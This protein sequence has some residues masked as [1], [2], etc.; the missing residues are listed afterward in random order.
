MT[1]EK[2]AQEKKNIDPSQMEVPSEL[3]ILTL[4][5]FVFFPG[6]GF[7]LQVKNEPS[8]KLIDDILLGDRL[9]ALVTHKP[10]EEE[11]EKVKPENLYS[12]GVM[13]YIHKL[14]KNQNQSYQILTTGL[15]T[16]KIGEYTQTHPYFKA[17]ITEVNRTRETGKDI[18]AHILSLHTQFKKLAELTKMSQ[19]I[20]K[21]V[22]SLN[23]PFH[24]SYFIASMLNLSVEKE[25]GLLETFDL[26]ELAHKVGSYLNESLETAEMSQQIQKSAKEDMDKK[27]REFYLR[28]QLQAIRKELGEDKGNPEIA[29]LRKKTEEA[30]LTEEAR[31][32]AE[33]ELKRLERIQ[34]SSPE[35]TVCRN[36]LDW[37]LEL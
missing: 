33:K 11:P 16:I 7:P 2:K 28:Q 34:P 26:R 32:T 5:G 31:R 12:V 9:L 17:V 29:E 23:D 22:D 30:E 14:I 35:Y 19:E 1:E 21:T 3:P 25:Q 13:G 4:H 36:Y 27:Q 24:I 6:M 15:K 20:T 37:I 18:N 8:K 10:L